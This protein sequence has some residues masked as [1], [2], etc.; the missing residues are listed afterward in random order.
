MNLILLKIEILTFCLCRYS[1]QSYIKVRYPARFWQITK[2]FIFIFM[3]FLH[4]FYFQSNLSKVFFLITVIH[5]VKFFSFFFKTEKRIR[6]SSL[7]T[8]IPLMKHCNQVVIFQWERYLQ[9]NKKKKKKNLF[10]VLDFW[11]QITGTTTFD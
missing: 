3:Q 6:Y 4:V 8:K 9:K 10:K 2:P 1:Y 7:N 11:K 5:V